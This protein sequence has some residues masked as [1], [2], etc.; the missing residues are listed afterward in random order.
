MLGGVCALPACSVGAV[1]WFGL[2]ADADERRP[3][4]PCAKVAL[5]KNG[6]AAASKSS[7][8]AAMKDWRD[9]WQVYYPL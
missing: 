2:M 3:V 6:G 7:E 8:L 4:S 1:G 5:R 9:A